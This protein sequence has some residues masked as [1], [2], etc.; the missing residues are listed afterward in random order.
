[1]AVDLRG[2]RFRAYSPQ[3]DDDTEEYDPVG[4]G[5]AD[6]TPGAVDLSAITIRAWEENELDNE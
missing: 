5:D 4:P 2:I 3:F 6:E 1:M